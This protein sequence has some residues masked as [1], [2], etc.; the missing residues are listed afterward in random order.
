MSTAPTPSPAPPSRGRVRA[1]PRREGAGTA[2]SPPR[3]GVTVGLIPFVL[4][5][6]GLVV[7]GVLVALVYLSGRDEPPAAATYT[8]AATD[9]VAISG[10]PS[11]ALTVSPSDSNM[12]VDVTYPDM[13]GTDRVQVVVMTGS[14][15]D[16]LEAE[17]FDD[18]QRVNL[19]EGQTQYRV[20][21]A[22]N[23]RFCAK[24]RVVR[25]AAESAWSDHKCEVQQEAEQ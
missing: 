20:N 2:D 12:Y 5:I 11:V 8:S 19:P 21:V 18:T 24:A 22:P 15:D 3:K 6:I 1:D 10:R 17:D 14:R 7:V 16:G 25:G 4:S 13:L 9:V 23:V